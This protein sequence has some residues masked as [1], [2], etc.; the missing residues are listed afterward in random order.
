MA[1]MTPGRARA[2]DARTPERAWNAAT[3]STRRWTRWRR[4]AS[5]SA[6]ASALRARAL[7]DD[8]AVVKVCGITTVEDCVRACASGA[9]LIG[10]IAWPRSARSV[11][12]DAARAIADAAKTHGAIPIAVFVDENAEE[13]TAMCDAIGC[14]H[15][16]LHGDGARAA[17]ETLPS[18]IKAIWVLNADADGKIV[19]KLPGD[20]EKL[21]A[22]RQKK[23]SGPQGWRAAIDFVSG[24]RRVVDWVLIDGV[25]AGSGTTFDWSGLKPP[26]GCSRKGWIL[27]GGLTPDN[28]ASAIDQLHPNG[29]DVASGVADEGGVRKDEAKVKAFIENARNAA[30]ASA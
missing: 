20:E 27:A 24:P 26:R 16:Q 4:R 28:V 1:R 14:D 3:A 25:N 22:E 6:S 9:D 12:R 8:R 23:M 15:A 29:V 13:I 2:C 30:A 11:T 21:I 17:L 5:A 19:T 18:R 10:V 7:A